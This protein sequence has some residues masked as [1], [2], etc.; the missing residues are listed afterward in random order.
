MTHGEVG[1]FLPMMLAAALTLATV[2]ATARRPPSVCARST[3][4]M[5]VLGA[6]TSIPVLVLLLTVFVLRVPWVGEVI[7]GGVHPGDHRSTMG[8]WLGLAG[9]AW[10][11]V[12]ASRGAVLL[13]RYRA[14]CALSSGGVRIVRSPRPMAFALPGA[15][16]TVVISEG[17]VSQLGSD[18][19]QAV[20]AHEQ[21]HATLRHGRLL[22]MARLFVLAAPYLHPVMRRYEFCLERIADEHAVAC[23]GDR[24]VVARALIRSAIAENAH[25]LSPAIA[26]VGVPARVEALL[27][28]RQR[29]VS[30]SPLISI[31]GVASVAGLGVLQWHHLAVAVRAVCSF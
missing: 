1:V 8:P 20:I 22:F 11:A 15:N 31:A 13:R 7:H 6:A 4:T 16:P 17:L 28:Q 12:A 25:T 14:E 10:A 30:N 24:S 19:I 2:N 29:T 26:R 5:M 23:C 18:E 9:L 27:P 21:A 3:F